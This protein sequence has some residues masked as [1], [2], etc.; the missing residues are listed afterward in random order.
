MS[1][2]ST[3]PI[4]SFLQVVAQK[5]KIA[6]SSSNKSL[7]EKVP[8]VILQMISKY[9]TH[10]QQTAPTAHL[11]SKQLTPLFEKINLDLSH[12]NITDKDL[13][14]VIKKYQGRLN[15][16]N[17]S[18]CPNIT[19]AGLKHIATL[20]NLT[21][22]NLVGC[23]LITDAG[24][25]HIATLKNLTSLNLGWCKRITDAGLTHIATLKN[26]TSLYLAWCRQITDAGIKK[27]QDLKQFNY[28]KKV[29]D[30]LNER[31]LLGDGID[32]IKE[33]QLK[34]LHK[35]IA[36]YSSMPSLAITR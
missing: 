2:S 14:L 13:G 6:D 21:S 7:I 1:I 16:L 9:N 4:V 11:V 17:L 26:L 27:L 35:L 12:S 18:K 22:L 23:R 34:D 28:E 15:S 30:Y 33:T 3:T 29:F 10:T 36:N 20:Q 25:T 31:D 5:T 32:S 19:N 24:L 8:D